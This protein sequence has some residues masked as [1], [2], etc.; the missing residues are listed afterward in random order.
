MSGVKCKRN[1]PQPDGG[2]GSGTI[3]MERE[4]PGLKDKPQ[5]ITQLPI[6]LWL[7]LALLLNF[8]QILLNHYFIQ[9]HAFSTH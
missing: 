2:Q 4:K 1:K 5:K 9:Y 3:D 7:W 6:R 8:Y